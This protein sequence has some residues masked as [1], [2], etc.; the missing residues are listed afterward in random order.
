[1]SAAVER[2]M[3]PYLLAYDSWKARAEALAAELARQTGQ[4]G[5]YWAKYKLNWLLPSIPEAQWAKEAKRRRELSRATCAAKKQAPG[6]RSL[7]PKCRTYVPIHEL[8][9]HVESCEGHICPYC[10]KQWLARKRLFMFHVE[11]CP[12]R[13]PDSQPGAHK[14]DAAI[15]AATE[16]MS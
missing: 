11:R 6:R 14:M 1:M 12:Q 10:G 13:P 15:H 16:K 7:C 9:G 5:G 8:V 4:G 2:I 3:K